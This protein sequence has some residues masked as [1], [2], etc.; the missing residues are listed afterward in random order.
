MQHDWRMTVYDLNLNGRMVELPADVHRFLYM[1]DGRASVEIGGAEV[2]LHPDE[3]TFSRSL[4]RIRGEG[5]VWVFEVG[6]GWRSLISDP[7]ASIVLS[8]RFGLDPAPLRL[9]R[10][11]RIESMSGSATPR[12]G[13]RGP[14]MRRLIKGRLL[15]EIG[16]NFERI[17]AGH[18]W[19]ET[20]HDPVVGTNV[21]TGNSAFVRVMLLPI[22]LEGGK[23]SFMPT[24]AEDAARP[25]AV[26]NRL[27]GEVVIEG[28]PG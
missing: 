24:T 9:L 14:G 22:D 18:A 3:G 2:D 13:H 17:D 16:D 5:V 8:R 25:R 26:V 20:G 11:D 7:A 6:P 21:H 1:P 28:T 19:F 27:F 10:A 12:H 4:A 23:S 15:A